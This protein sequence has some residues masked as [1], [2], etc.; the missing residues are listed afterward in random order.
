[1]LIVS[2]TAEEK[3]R[4]IE[5]YQSNWKQEKKKRSNFQDGRNNNKVMN[6]YTYQKSVTYF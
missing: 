5:N 2:K 1:M 3:G 6:K 4:N